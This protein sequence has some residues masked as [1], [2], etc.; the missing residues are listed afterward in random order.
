M[1]VMRHQLGAIR[2]VFDLNV[3]KQSVLMHG[4]KHFATNPDIHQQIAW[5]TLTQITEGDL[6]R[7]R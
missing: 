4:L 7:L 1:T 5:Q 2:G 6:S 3:L